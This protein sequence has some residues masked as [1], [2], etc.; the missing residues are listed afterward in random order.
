MQKVVRPKRLNVGWWD[1]GERLDEPRCHGGPRPWHPV[2]AVFD[3]VDGFV[4][5]VEE[6]KR[7]TPVLFGRGGRN[8][9]ILF[10]FGHLDG[11]LGF[12]GYI[13]DCVRFLQPFRRARVALFF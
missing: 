10:Q 9:E 3:G 2:V 4:V 11:V 1:V 7:F 5:A 13:F 12:N 6:L 8:G